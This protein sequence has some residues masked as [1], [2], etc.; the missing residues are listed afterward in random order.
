MKKSLSAF[1]AVILACMVIFTGCGKVT[2]KLDELFP[3][4]TNR[5]DA[6]EDPQKLSLPN[7][8][9]R[10]YT[11]LLT[12]QADREDELTTVSLLTFHTEEKSVHWLQLPNNLFVNT[13]GTTLAGVFSDAYQAELALESATADTAAIK[14]V[15]AIRVLLTQGYTVPIDYYVNF[16]PDQLSSLITALQGIPIHLPFEIGSL[17]VGD[18]VLNGDGVRQYLTSN[19]FAD[20]TEGLMAARKYFASALWERAREII[21]PE[22]LSLYSAD[23]RG[24][25]TT[26]IPYTGGEDIFFWR[27]FLQADPEEIRITHA[28]SQIVMH[29]GRQCSVL[30]RANALRQLNE[31][32][33]IYEDAL[34]EGQ[35]DPSALFV[36]GS[37]QLVLTVYYSSATLPRLYSMAELADGA[38]EIRN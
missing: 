32:M 5:S 17:S 11:V 1:F 16:A 28:S 21:T 27:R 19:E 25:M 2:E 34:E 9:G 26:N 31:Q 6:V 15:E 12:V 33:G 30:M 7:R 29:S 23:L 10:T 3:E 20:A 14:G 24:R 4:E 13:A 8:V 37:S 18:Q 35:F 38:V 36:D 22:N